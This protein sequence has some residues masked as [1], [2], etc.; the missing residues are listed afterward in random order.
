MSIKPV[1]LFFCILCSIQSLSGQCGVV[2]NIPVMDD[3]TTLISILV[4]SLISDTLGNNGQG[5]CGIGIEFRHEF[6]GDL[7]IELFSPSGQM[8]QLVGPGVPVSGSTSGTRWN[9]LFVPCNTTA[10]PDPGFSE[11]WDNLQPWGLLGNYTGQYYPMTG[12]LDDF[13]TGPVNGNWTLRVTDVSQFGSG[14][15]LSVRLFFCNSEGVNCDECKVDAGNLYADSVNICQS[16]S[17]I[18]LQNYQEIFPLYPK[19]TANYFYKWALFTD[20]SLV[21]LFTQGVL[22]SLPVGHYQLCNIQYAK[23]EENRIPSLPLQL[24][25]T[26]IN[27]FFEEELICAGVGIECIPIEIYPSTDT[28]FLDTLLCKGTTIELYQNLITEEGIY[29]FQIPGQ[30]CD[31]ILNVTVRSINFDVSVS[32]ETDTINCTNPVLELTAVVSDPSLNPLFYQWFTQDGMI[33]SGQDSVTVQVNKAGIYQVIATDLICTDSAFLEIF[34]DEEVPDLEI[35]GGNTLTCFADSLTLEV[36][37][38]IDLSSVVW[39]SDQPFLTDGDNIRVFT[40]GQYTVDVLSADGCSGTTSVLIVLI[41]TIASFSVLGGDITCLQDSLTLDVIHSLSGN[42]S[43]VWTGVVPG[44]ENLKNPVVVNGGTKQVTV[45]DQATGCFAVE[46]INVADNRNFPVLS[47]TAD[48]LTCGSSE[49]IPEWT[50]SIPLTEYQWSGPGV[51]SSDSVVMISQSGSFIFTGTT[52]DGC[53]TTVPFIVFQDTVAAL[54]ELNAAALSC[55]MDST[56]I[57]MESDKVLVAY[58][59]MNPVNV[60]FSNEREPWVGLVGQYHV[61]VTDINGCISYAS[62][63]VSGDSDLPNI[64]FEI[65]TITCLQPLPQIIADKTTGYQFVWEFPDFTTSFN[66]EPIISLPGNYKVTVTD[67]L[68]PL[69]VEYHEFFITDERQFAQ[70]EKNIGEITCT[71]DSAGIQIQPNIAD[72]SVTVT[73]PSFFLAD[74]FNFF[75]RSVGTYYVEVTTGEGCLTID[76]FVVVLNDIRPEISSLVE[77]QITCRTTEALVSFTSSIIGTLFEVFSGTVKIDEGSNVAISDTGMYV[78]YGLAPNNCRDTT[79]FTIGIDTLS[80]DINISLPDTITCL[81]D[82]VVLLAN[83]SANNPI[84]EWNGTLGN[85]FFATSGGIYR[86]VVTDSL[87]GCQTVDSVI[88]VENKVFVEYSIQNSEINCNNAVAGITII[89]GNKF[90][91]IRWAASNPELINDGVLT[92]TTDTPGIYYFAV[93]SEESC[94]TIDSLIVVENINPPNILLISSPEINCSNRTVEISL[95]TESNTDQVVW[96]SPSSVILEG[97]NHFVNEAGVYRITVTGDNGCVTDTTAEVI[98]NLDLPQYS[99]F[100]DSLSCQKGKGVIGV[101]TQD[102]IIGYEW[103][104]PSQFQSS[105]QSPLVTEVGFYTVIVTK[106]NGCTDTTRIYVK[107]DYDMPEFSIPDTF[108]IPC[109][110]SL[111]MLKT[112]NLDSIEAYYWEREGVLFSTEATPLTNISGKYTVRVT[113]LNGCRSVVEFEVVQLTLPPGFSF[114]TDTI[115]CKHPI[116]FLQANSLAGNVQYTWLSPSGVI[117]ESNISE[118]NESGLHTLIVRDNN[119]CFD[120][121]S[122]LV[123]ADT[124]RPDIDIQQEGSILCDQREVLLFIPDSLQNS[125]FTY[126]WTGNVDQLL[127]DPT[128]PSVN[129]RNPGLFILNLTNNQNGC[130]NQLAY[131][132]VELPGDFDSIPFDL[133]QPVCFDYPFGSIEIGNL[134]GV[135]PYMVSLNNVPLGNVFSINNLSSGDYLLAVTDNIGCTTD[136]SFTILPAGDLSIDLPVDTT[137][138]LGDSI[139]L[140]FDIES[141]TDR[142]YGVTLFENGTVLCSSDCMFPFIV[143]PERTSIYNILLETEDGRCVYDHQI[144]V[145]VYEKIFDGIPNIITP[146]AVQEQNRYFYI[147]ERNGIEKILS[148]EIYDKWATPMFVRYNISTGSYL[149][150]WDGTFR[151]TLAEEGVYVVICDLLLSNNQVVKYRGTLTLLR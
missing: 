44:T 96:T 50:S 113:G 15:I 147:P 92:F 86:I 79:F 52:D 119:N 93:E 80:P 123:A 88:V 76:S 78:V 105:L 126:L 37:S 36:V 89:P 150:G 51:F 103:S 111:I 31:T 102:Q 9:V 57:F 48:T 16:S 33:V 81:T 95:N 32:Y 28:I 23:A 132:V 100:T 131:E 71:V 114:Q 12:C 1:I 107:G 94:I 90:K 138:L 18:L 125:D 115:S 148:I 54:L 38:D 26:E 14:R 35:T 104:G 85:P 55:S 118:S 42:Y 145:T 19:D 110:S 72:V 84:F 7:N 144:F 61:T 99:V 53:T 83:S 47:V 127:T 13:D 122:V 70:I 75:V 128:V 17:D 22:P 39:T 124:L 151:G 69:C 97:N 25:K 146:N 109:D 137:I 67:I 21:E 73:G 68:N 20:T 2:R 8:V 135:E 143:T 139:V 40:P 34:L 112:E 134:Q 82:E 27:N 49:I 130:V 60:I 149:D 64:M 133:R 116:A 136:T 106:E 140:E 41:D 65:P 5:L 74:S 142:G 98:L 66:A 11:V 45:T 120:T 59:W 129:I 6:I 10:S 87:N 24:D 56:R 91:E 101:N 4:D 108:L 121:V 63:E 29:Q 77:N 62:T 30:F 3:D 43:Y 117:T 141:W 46:N 58:T